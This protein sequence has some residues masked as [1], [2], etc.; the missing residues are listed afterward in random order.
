MAGEEE[1][2]KSGRAEEGRGGRDD[3]GKSGG[4]VRRVEGKRRMR[5]AYD[6]NRDNKSSDVALSADEVVARQQVVEADVGAD[7]EG[8]DDAGQEGLQPAQ[9]ARDVVDVCVGGG[10]SVSGGGGGGEAGRRG[11]L[12]A[13]LGF[14]G[15]VHGWRVGLVM[16]W[17]GEEVDVV[18]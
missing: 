6:D 13:G 18:G 16:L 7:A 2:G 1:K 15:H 17:M 8:G 12:H 9:H 4:Q 11:R 3:E 10:G 14:H 5:A